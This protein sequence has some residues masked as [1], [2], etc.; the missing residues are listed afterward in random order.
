VFQPCLCDVDA[1]LP[2]FAR[3]QREYRPIASYPSRAERPRL[4]LVLPTINPQQAF[5]GIATALKLF[6]DWTACLGPDYDRRIIVTDAEIEAEAYSSLPGFTPTPFTQ[7]LDQSQSCIVDAKERAGGRLDLRAR[8][9]FVATAWWTVDTVRALER[10]RA[11]TFGER[12]PFV[13]LIQDDEPNFDGWGSRCVLAE[14]TYRHRDETI[15]VLNSEELYA[16]MLEK[17]DFAHAFCL[18]YELNQ[19]IASRLAPQPRERTILIY[20]R[21]TV[22]RNA[23]EVVCSALKSWQQRDP[24]RASRWRIVFLGESFEEPLAYPVQNASVEGKVSL[25]AYADHL[26]RAAVGVS[27]MVS[28]HPSYPPLEM[29]EA[30]VLTIANSRPGKDLRSRCP[31]IVSI[32]DLT[33]STLAAAIEQAVATMEPRIGMI[34]ERRVLL[35]PPPTGPRAD[36]HVIASVLRDALA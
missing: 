23:F 10:D 17:H 24:I 7:S 6:S 30:G 3:T 26:N 18:P 11:R 20:G 27:L 31:E 36:P 8:E 33:P 35:K 28:P 14:S 32:D 22:A 16:T 5:G 29:A 25:E 19:L 21:P 12:R 13:Y 1:E 15:A 34:V 9:V 2:P 4:N